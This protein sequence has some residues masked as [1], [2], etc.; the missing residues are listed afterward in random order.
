M[1]I[2]RLFLLLLLSIPLCVS[3]Q[4]KMTPQEYIDLYKPLAM[5]SMSEYKIPA[6]ITLAQGLLESGNGGSELTVKANNHF[7]IKCRKSW[8]GP[9]VY[10]DDDAKGECFRKYRSARASY[11]DHSQFLTGSP[12]YASLF[13]LDITDY[14]GWARGLKAAGYATNPRYAEILIDLIERYK[15]QN[16]RAG[17]GA[18]LGGGIFGSSRGGGDLQEQKAW[19][20]THPVERNNGLRAIVAVSGDSFATIAA[21]YHTSERRLLKINDMP[22]GAELKSGM[23]IYIDP[24]A[25]RSRKA[26]SHRVNSGESYHSISQKYGIKLK[27]LLK[28]NPTTRISP[29]RVG[30]VLM[31]R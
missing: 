4:Y 11:A 28:M 3:A 24:K 7:G 2:L 16:L 17:R 27:S 10:H 6:C 19:F 30:Q 31:L 15:L 9:R 20:K 14:K 29:P 8:V 18:K 25:T 23:A 13:K 1:S 22:R 26:A 12:R 5:A 21:K